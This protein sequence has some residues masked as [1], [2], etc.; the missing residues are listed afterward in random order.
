MTKLKLFGTTL[1]TILFLTS[2]AKQMD[3]NVYTS[4]AA[5]GKVIEGT[6]ISS[7]PVTVKSSDKLQDNTMG[8]IGGGLLGAVAGSTVGKGTGQGLAAI[9]AGMLGAAAGAYAQDKLGNSDGMEYV[10][11]IDK[12]Y[13]NSIPENVN[14]RSVSFGDK[15]IAQEVSQSTSVQTTKTDLISVVQGKDTAF[16]P[17][18][19]VLVIYSDDR[20]R[21]APAY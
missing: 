21:L 3:S 6:V 18:Q 9:G 7:R 15:S 20:P 1:I 14:K 10:I 4:G 13:V 8:M 12:K 17:G 5:V 11:R 16:N 19:R 2:C